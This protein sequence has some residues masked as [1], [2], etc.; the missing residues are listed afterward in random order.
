LKRYEYLRRKEG[1]DY[2][3]IE[4]INREEDLYEQLAA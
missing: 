3:F 1:F 2:S 4:K